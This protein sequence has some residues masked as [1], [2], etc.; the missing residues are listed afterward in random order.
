MTKQE[1]I[2]EAIGKSVSQVNRIIGE[3]AGLMLEDS[4]KFYGA[5][6]C[7]IIERNEEMITVPRREYKAMAMFAK[8]ALEMF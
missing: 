8:K 2:A 7:E 5:I 4:P 6:G 3:K 1:M